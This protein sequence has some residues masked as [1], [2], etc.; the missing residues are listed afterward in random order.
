MKDRIVFVRYKSF[1]VSVVY[2]KKEENNNVDE[3]VE[4]LRNKIKGSN[5]TIIGVANV[6]HIEFIN[7]GFGSV[8]MMDF[9]TGIEDFFEKDM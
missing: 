2:I 5:F 4:K 7:G 1:D 8:S 6:E 3:D 9:R